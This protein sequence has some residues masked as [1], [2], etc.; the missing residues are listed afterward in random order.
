DDPGR[1][2][3]S[4]GG[5]G[6][7]V[8]AEAALDVERLPAR[9]LLPLGEAEAELARLAQHCPVDLARPAAADVADQELNGPPDRRVGAAALAERVDPVVQ[10]DPVPDRSVDDQDR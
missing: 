10:A 8:G 1:S 3:T 4:E 6:A 7:L 9:A 2:A 5:H